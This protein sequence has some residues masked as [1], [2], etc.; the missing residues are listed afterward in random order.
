MP[1]GLTAVR[2][3]EDVVF[4][5]IRFGAERFPR[6]RVECWTIDAP[7]AVWQILIIQLA[8]IRIHRRLQRTNRVKALH[9]LIA[10]RS[11][12]RFVSEAN[13]RSV[14][15]FEIFALLTDL[16]LSGG[17]AWSIGHG[18]HPQD[19]IPRLVRILHERD[20]VLDR[21]SVV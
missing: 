20:S 21:K 8:V 9:D 19:F 14:C 10:A 4:L 5:P 17:R 1:A 12:N 7:A 11:V 15:A 3:L 18:S 13:A 2:S 6:R 16:S